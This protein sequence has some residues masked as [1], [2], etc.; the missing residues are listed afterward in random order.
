MCTTYTDLRFYKGL[1]GKEGV[2]GGGDSYFSTDKSQKKTRFFI[3][4]FPSNG[5]HIKNLK[6]I[7]KEK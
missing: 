6:G 3:H 4:L 7:V 2:E 1:N 5:Q